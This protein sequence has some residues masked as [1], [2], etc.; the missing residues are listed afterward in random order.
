[1]SIHGI[2]TWPGIE[3][4]V[5]CSYTCSL[6]ITPG[7]ASLV[8]PLQAEP[9][10]PEGT[11]TI[12]DGTFG[13]IVLKDCRIAR[14]ES[15]DLPGGAKGLALQIL[16]RR[17]RWKYGAISGWYNQVDPD[18]DPDGLPKGEFTTRYGPFVPGTERDVLELIKL[19]TKSLDEELWTA[20]GLPK[21]ARPPA[22]W[23]RVNPAAALQGVAD[24]VLARVC[25]QPTEQGR[26]LI[27][28]PGLGTNAVRA[29]WPVISDD[30]GLKAVTPPDG[31]VVFT[32]PIRC[33]WF[34][35]LEPVG[36]ERDG[37]WR[38]IDDLSYKP[39]KGWNNLSPGINH[40][41]TV[42]Q[43]DWRSLDEAKDAARQYVWR[44]YRIKV[45][46]E[47]PF[48]FPASGI[49][50]TIK[51]RKQIRLESRI[52]TT[53]KDRTGQVITDDPYCVG[54]AYVVTLG[55]KKLVNERSTSSRM[56]ESFSIDAERG[57]VMF[58]RPVYK[59]DPE[60]TT[61][62]AITP[63]I[64]VY[65]SFQVRDEATHQFLDY[66]VAD[67]PDTVKDGWKT[68]AKVEVL[69]HPELNPVF[70]LVYDE[71]LGDDPFLKSN[72]DAIR[73]EADHYIAAA[74]K[75]ST[76]MPLTTTRTYAGIFPVSPDS[77]VDQ[78]T[79]SVGGGGP[80]TTTVSVNTEHATWLPPF[81]ERR[82][83]EKADRPVRG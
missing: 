22:D 7:V 80:A 40:W 68:T 18:P 71:L 19:C 6:G 2:A 23:K 44:A 28:S 20:V 30:P 17:W 36:P 42:N 82:R 64:A 75:Q 55:T 15:V 66:F 27:T 54:D 26:I 53:E 14:A 48:T 83:N 21:A 58:S 67:D 45:D 39:D 49:L 62:R 4:F 61:F 50:P 8:V 60:S 56:K 57:L 79:W 25:Y 43:G 10:P 3:G 59:L 77:F 63:E 73:A 41:R 9:I 74:K 11:L 51:N 38:P 70:W 29:D 31:F 5:S 1:M 33:S 78:V 72:R 52:W 24:S 69:P 46:S 13:K 47:H 32:G 81:A 65:T 35:Q 76:E 16:D 12:T 34:F 37:T